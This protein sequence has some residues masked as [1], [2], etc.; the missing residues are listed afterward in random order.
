[1]YESGKTKAEIA[2]ITG[3]TRDTVREII[4]GRGITAGKDIDIHSLI[5][6]KPRTPKPCV[7]SG[8][9]YMDL[10]PLFS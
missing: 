10:T 5:Y 4:A 6:A 1:M 9:R 7:V 8:K 2:Q 3:Y